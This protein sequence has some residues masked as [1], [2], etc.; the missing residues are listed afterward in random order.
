MLARNSFAL[1]LSVLYFFGE[2][3]QEVV[4]VTNQL[5][6]RTQCAL[7][8]PC[9]AFSLAYLLIAHMMAAMSHMCPFEPVVTTTEKRRIIF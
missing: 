1:T 9:L 8:W 5:A 7:P 6:L 3:A 4:Y 2:R